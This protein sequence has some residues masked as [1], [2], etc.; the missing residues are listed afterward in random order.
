MIALT[1]EPEG[2]GLI[3]LKNSE[4]FKNLKLSVRLT[5]NKLG[6]QKVY[7]RADEE[8]EGYLSVQLKSNFL[9]IEEDGEAIYELDLNEHEKIIPQ[10]I[11]EDMKETLSAE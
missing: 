5:G 2:R 6:T 8:L 3:K 10:T 7:L 4:G 9:Y 1:S 11:E